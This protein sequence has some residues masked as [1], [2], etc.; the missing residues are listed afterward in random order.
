MVGEPL[1]VTV[2]VYTSTWFTSPPEFSEI[3]VPRA[4]MAR[5]EQRTGSMMKTIGK[6]RYPAIEQKFVVY[7]SQIG[8]N[9]LPSITIVTEC[10]PEGDY[11]ARKR[12]I[13]SPERTFSVLAPPDGIDTDK[14]LTAYNVRLSESWDRPLENLKAGDVLERRITIRASGALAALISPLDLGDIEFGKIYPKEPN[15]ANV[16]NKASFFRASNGNCDLS[17][18]K[19]RRFQH[20]RNSVFLV[21]P[22]VQKAGTHQS[23]RRRIDHC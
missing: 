14:W 4:L 16:Q 3:Q 21:Q 2:T 9:S 11:K 1:V 20:T 23:A 8:E 22:A 6:K 10:P 7:P 18:R 17:D 13:K 12:T 19:G 15:L 5:L